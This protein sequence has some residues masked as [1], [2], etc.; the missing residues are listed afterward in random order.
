MQAT[1]PA[2]RLDYRF[3][4]DLD[5]LMDIAAAHVGP[6]LQFAA[7]LIGHYDGVDQS[8]FDAEG[9]LD[10]ALQ[11]FNLRAWYD[12]YAIDLRK[13]W[14]QRGHWRSPKEL[15]ALNPHVD[16]LM[17][18]FGIFSWL[19]DDGRMRVLIPLVTDVRALGPATMRR[20]LQTIG[21]IARAIYGRLQDRIRKLFLKV[22]D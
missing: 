21:V 17:W 19:N 15:L 1:I 13:F 20:P 2:A 7:R 6:V 16:R 3:H 18:Q 9:R 10:A 22:R 12:I 4:G 5:K 11:K 8:S 14:N